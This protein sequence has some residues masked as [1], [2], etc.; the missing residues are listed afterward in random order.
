MPNDPKR[1]KIVDRLVTVLKTIVAGNNYFFTPY[2]IAKGFIS[3]PTGFPVYMVLSETGG[4]MTE[5]L[6]QQWEETFYVS[7]RGVVQSTSDVVT[8][9][10]RAIRD[11]RKAIN[12]D[13]KPE[14]GA[15]SLI[16]L[17]SS[18]KIDGPPD[19]DYGFEGTHFFGYFSQRIKIQIFGEIGEI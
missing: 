17:A 18:I 4:G 12:D 6:D 8:P 1:L 7:I 15:G 11:V 5:E 16:T 19:I 10:E 9:M 14:A 2:E 3:S 13:F